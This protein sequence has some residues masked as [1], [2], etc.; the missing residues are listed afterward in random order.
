M[1][2]VSIVSPADIGPGRT[3]LFWFDR[4]LRPSARPRLR[5]ALHWL[6]EVAAGR[7]GEGLCRQLDSGAD[8]SVHATLSGRFLAAV[9]LDEEG[10]LRL[11]L[12]RW[13]ASSLHVET[14][15]AAPPDPGPLSRAILALDSGAPEDAAT[16]LAS[17]ILE[18]GWKAAAA[19][20]AAELSRRTARG[21]AILDR[22]F[23]FTP[24]GLAAYRAALEGGLAERHLSRALEGECTVEAHL[25]CF[26]RAEWPRRWDILAAAKAVAEEGGRVV[27]CP[28]QESDRA[29]RGNARQNT[30]ALAA[31]LLFP[32]SASG[33]EIG[34]TDTRT[35]AAPVLAHSLPALLRAYDFGAEPFEWLA[36]SH[37]GDVRASVSLSVPGVMAG[38]WLR[39]PG[40]RD[41]TFFEVYS[42]VSVAVQRALRRWLPYVYFSNLDRFEDL[43]VAYP[44]VFYGRTYP[45]SGQPRSNFAHDLVTLEDPGVARPWAARPLSAA[46]TRAERLLLAAGRK[47]VAHL[48]ESWRAHDVLAG[49]VR[50]PRFINA[51]LS[52]DAFFIDRLVSLGLAGRDL[53]SR[54]AVN[55]RRT[56]KDLAAFADEFTRAVNRKLRR[57]YGGQEF[58][59]LGS[60]LL[61]EATRALSAA[62]DGNAA[63]TAI[64]RLSDAD[65]EQTFTNA[66]LRT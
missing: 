51:L 5:F 55:P 27:V 52:A 3:L 53:S 16:R 29:R 31:P 25:P 23:D 12:S 45:C 57:L 14:G 59:A 4:S 8:A 43:P 63:I 33:F 60:L 26:S 35:G 19:R 20:C 2:P 61:L 66:A 40:E 34:F 49:I 38:A 7:F 42:K 17:E 28:A 9:A 64:L 44:L 15:A 13:R 37:P 36:E 39:A 48:Y 56:T 58:I 47:N 6:Q 24:E 50:R 54:L 62:L 21:N 11:R 30:L 22:S 10:R 18:Q 41:P 32:E 46:L 1:S 65:R